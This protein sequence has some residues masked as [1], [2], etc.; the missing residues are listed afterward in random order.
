MIDLKGGEPNKEQHKHKNKTLSRMPTSNPMMSNSRVVRS[1][2]KIVRMK[3]TDLRR[4]NGRVDNL[5]DCTI[6]G[7]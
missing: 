6:L 4:S 2:Q 3:R 5:S 1:C 7:A